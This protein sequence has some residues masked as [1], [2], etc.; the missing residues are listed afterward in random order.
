[1]RGISKI[2]EGEKK[3]QVSTFPV[4]VATRHDEKKIRILCG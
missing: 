4:S 2:P 1:M 3:T